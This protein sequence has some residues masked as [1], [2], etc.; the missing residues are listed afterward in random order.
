M[1]DCHP[2]E[3]KGMRSTR[4]GIIAAAPITLAALMLSGCATSPSSTGRPDQDSPSTSAPSDAASTES[5]APGGQSSGDGCWVHLFDSDDFQE[6]DDHFLLTEAGKYDNLAQLPGASKD[7]TDE[8][9]SIKVGPNAT[10]TVWPRTNFAG[11][12]QI[13]EPGSEHPS[14]DEP[15]SLEM[16]CTR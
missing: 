10:V 12:K 8:A 11:T 9:D 15:S 5:S 14:V 3:S 16:A 2:I 6:S 1:N 4:T 7:W 13:L